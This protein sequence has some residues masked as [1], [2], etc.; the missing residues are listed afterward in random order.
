MWISLFEFL[1]SS[2]FS[3]C[4]N[5]D[6]W[7]YFIFSFEKIIFKLS[8]FFR[9]DGSD[10]GLVFAWRPWTINIWYMKTRDQC[11]YELQTSEEFNFFPRLY[12]LWHQ[13][14][15]KWNPRDLTSLACKI[16]FSNNQWHKNNSVKFATLTVVKNLTT[17]VWNKQC[18]SWCHKLFVASL[19]HC[20]FKIR[21]LDDN[22][23]PVDI[24]PL[25]WCWFLFGRSGCV[26]FLL[27]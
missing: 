8:I 22:S 18:I 17:K 26:L 15:W 23:Q 6:L 19:L 5:S 7:Q 21:E 9:M 16:E 1:F 14:L 27:F 25:G 24:V 20:Y 4:S 2:T 12:Y 10:W 3:D 13:K 11:F